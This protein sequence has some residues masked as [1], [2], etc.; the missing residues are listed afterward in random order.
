VH[1]ISIWTDGSA[2]PNPGRGG[3]C[4]ILL[5]IVEGEIQAERVIGGSD[6]VSTNN[7]MELQAAISALKALKPEAVQHTIVLKT[8]SNYMKDNL[9]YVPRWQAKGWRG[10]KGPIANVDLWKELYTLTQAYKVEFKWVEAHAG[11][12]YNKRC[13]QIAG[14][15]A[16][17]EIPEGVTIIDSNLS[18]C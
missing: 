12:T 3:W 15:L 9:Q 10:S 4:A 14:A 13:D 16:H 2:V 5:Y 18:Y 7:R 6:P 8:D 17:G 11:D 1:N